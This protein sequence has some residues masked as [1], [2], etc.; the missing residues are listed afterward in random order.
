VG[1]SPAASV[2]I[3]FDL[4]P[5]PRD[6]F[7]L[8]GRSQHHDHRVR[9]AWVSPVTQ[10]RPP[11]ITSKPATR[12]GEVMVAADRREV[13]GWGQPE[14]RRPDSSIST[15]RVVSRGPHFLF[16]RSRATIC[17]KEQRL[18]GT[19]TPLWSLEVS[20]HSNRF[21]PANSRWGIR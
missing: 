19:G 1:H 18:A 10:N 4:I 17:S 6:E 8:P 7:R 5:I 20:N 9:A 2:M 12:G 21:G 15:P 14:H 13:K 3:L 11:V 16:S